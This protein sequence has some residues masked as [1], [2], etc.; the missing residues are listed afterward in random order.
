MVSR[1][2][3]PFEAGHRNSNSRAGVAWIVSR[4]DEYDVDEGAIS[5][6]DRE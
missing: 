6:N 5:K 1:G 3:E 4:R 2:R